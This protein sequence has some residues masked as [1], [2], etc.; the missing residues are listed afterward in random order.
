M[1]WLWD[2]RATRTVITFL[3]DTRVGCITMERV[4][5]EEGEERDERKVE[6]DRRDIHVHAR[7]G[8]SHVLRWCCALLFF[9]F[10]FITFLTFL[11]FPLLTCLLS[12]PS[13]ITLFFFIK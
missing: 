5:P 4:F 7:A 13:V 10:L 11:T 9:L 8:E 3:G 1:K 2:E 12:L 6:K